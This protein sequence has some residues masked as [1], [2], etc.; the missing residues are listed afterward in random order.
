MSLKEVQE[1]DVIKQNLAIANGI[2]EER[3]IVLDCYRSDM[4]YIKKS[5]MSSNLPVLLNFTE[6]D[7]DWSQCDEFATSSRVCEACCYWN[8][9]INNYKEI[10]DM[11]HMH[12][13]T[14]QRYIRKG[15]ELNL[16]TD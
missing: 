13:G 9:C 7:I 14:I 12:K 8:Q 11:M 4:Q 3:Y 1:N 5:I 2:E 16:I 10:A 15:R 6:Y